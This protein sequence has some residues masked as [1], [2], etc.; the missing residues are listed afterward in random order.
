MGLATAKV[1][2][3][4]HNWITPLSAQTLQGTDEELTQAISE[5]GTLKEIAWNTNQQ[6][7]G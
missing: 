6:S 7:S 2:L 5:I 4:I 1:G 3:Q